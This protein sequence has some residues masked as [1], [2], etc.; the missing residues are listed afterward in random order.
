[1]KEVQKIIEKA[2]FAAGS[3]MPLGGFYFFANNK[4]TD[5]A[6]VAVA[7]GR[8][9]MPGFMALD[10]M[11]RRNADAEKMEKARE[12]L[13]AGYDVAFF[14]TEETARCL[15]WRLTLRKK[16]E[17]PEKEAEKDESAPAP[18]KKK[19]TKTKK[20]EKK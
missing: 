16:D 8:M 15:L 6:Y 11:F 10:I 14:K 13:I 20:T 5:A 18:K 7:R 19:S 12:L 17:Q 1:M 3:G 4:E 9:A 2:G